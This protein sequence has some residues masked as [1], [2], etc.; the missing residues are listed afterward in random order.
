MF[1]PSEKAI[2]E[3]KIVPFIF[4]FFFYWRFFP[5]YLLMGKNS[6][7]AFSSCRILS[8]FYLRF[9]DFH[10]NPIAFYF[11]YGLGINISNK[12]EHVP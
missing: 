5:E 12:F 8:S 4:C 2:L 10:R 11:F 3:Y 1:Q 7:L 6:E 9:T